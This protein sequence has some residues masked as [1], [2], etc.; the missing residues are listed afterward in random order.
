MKRLVLSLAAAALLAGPAIAD[1]ITQ[2]TFEVSVPTTAGPHAAE[3]GSGEALGFHSDPNTVYS[4]PVGNGSLE[5]FSSNTWNAGDYYQFKTSTLGYENITFQFDQTRSST[6]PGVFDVEWSTDGTT[7]STLV[8][9][10][11][12]G[13]VTW[14]S[15]TYNPASTFGPHAAPAAL[16]DQPV[17]YFRLTAQVAGSGAAGTNRVDDVIVGGSVIPEPAS[18]ILLAL[19]GIS[20]LRR[21]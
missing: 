2:W 4:N 11:S 19:G 21:R 3:I 10:Y 16:D 9:D 18:L 5:S 14:S 8:D 15:I 7:W 20:L 17:V 13:V 1:T 6:G 12:V